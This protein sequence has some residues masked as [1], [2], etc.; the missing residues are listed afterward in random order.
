LSVSLK[1]IVKEG[2]YLKDPQDSSL[3]RAILKYSV[4]LIDEI[5]LESFTF[6]KLAA[7]MG[8]TEASV[9]RYFPN[10]HVLLVYLAS[11]YWEWISYR[12]EFETRNIEDPYQRMKIIIGI[13]VDTAKA[14]DDID[15]LDLDLLHQIIV[16]EG[17]KAYHTKH[18]DDENQQGFFM[19]YKTLCSDLAEII[20]ECNPKFPYPRALASTLI[21]MANH[22][23]Y[24]AEH[25]P[26]LTDIN[27]T[28]GD[29]SEAKKLLCHL[30]N[31]WVCAKP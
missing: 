25:L 28:P 4:Q 30:F 8:S 19:T 18:V 7:K 20:T 1:I 6:R 5:G 23:V 3:G 17:T 11:F 29:L 12:I 31:S 9:Y 22:H 27:Y 15:I 26:A 2:L 13:L 24:F 10:K 14:A 21:E 16:A